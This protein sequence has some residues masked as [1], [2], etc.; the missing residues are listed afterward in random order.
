MITTAKTYNDWKYLFDLSEADISEYPMNACNQKVYFRLGKH[1]H[2][3][4]VLFFPAM[5]LAGRNSFG[6]IQ[7]LVVPTEAGANALTL[8]SRWI[9]RKSLI[10][11]HDRHFNYLSEIVNT[12]PLNE[13]YSL[14]EP[15]EDEEEFAKHDHHKLYEKLYSEN[16][17][18]AR[19]HRA[20][21]RLGKA[22]STKSVIHF[23]VLIKDTRISF[24]KAQFLVLP[25]GEDAYRSRLGQ[26]WVARETLVMDHDRLFQQFCDARSSTEDAL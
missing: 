9:E 2:E 24:G 1:D 25:Y 14:Q 4:D 26:R 20:F 3:K 12:E 10:M 5:S 16:P 22:D 7:V 13:N 8:G 19:Y 23:P 6:K 15:V 17:C 18:C 11:A 21:F